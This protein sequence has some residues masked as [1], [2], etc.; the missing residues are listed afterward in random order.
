MLASLNTLE[1]DTEEDSP[2]EPRMTAPTESGILGVP[3]ALGEEQFRLTTKN[4][5]ITSGENST[6]DKLSF[7][8]WLHK[9]PTKQ[10]E[11]RE[12]PQTLHNRRPLDN[13]NDLMDN[14]EDYNKH[15]D[16]H[17]EGLSK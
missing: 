6:S 9:E 3:L 16:P 5:M 7:R 4:Q 13:N 10:R 12:T 14:Q 1:S 2:E 15:E 8:G 11:A 17:G